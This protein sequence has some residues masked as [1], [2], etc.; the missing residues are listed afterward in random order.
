MYAQAAQA[1][2]DVLVAAVY[3]FDVV[4]P[5]GALGAHCGDE[6]GDARTD[7]RTGH[8]AGPQA[9][10]VV[11]AHDDGAVGVLLFQ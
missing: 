8:A 11:V 5:A 4:Y 6:Q 1:L 7:V 10:L 9:H 2:L 3:L